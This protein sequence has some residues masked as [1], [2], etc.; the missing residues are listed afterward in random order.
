MTAVRWILLIMAMSFAISG[1][2]EPLLP[3]YEQPFNAISTAHTFLLILLYYM[4]CV[5]D[6]AARGIQ[7]PR[8]APLL[9]A[10]LLPVGVPYYFFKTMPGRQAALYTLAAAGFFILL[11]LVYFA[12]FEAGMRF[13]RGQSS[14]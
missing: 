10:L 1:F 9:T 3:N 13:W 4:W 5:A 12:A 2:T 14:W 8:W 6:A 7:P 11:M